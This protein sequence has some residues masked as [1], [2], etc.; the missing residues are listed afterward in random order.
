MQI[1]DNEY[2]KILEMFQKCTFTNYYIAQKTGLSNATLKNYR[3]NKTKPTVANILILKQF[4]ESQ[5]VKIELNS[6][7]NVNADKIHNSIINQINNE[8]NLTD[9]LNE[10]QKLVDFLKE[11]IKTKDETIKILLN[12]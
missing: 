12:K 1:S 11:Q 5:N 4:F 3:E 10:C 6:S 8:K 2:D 7:K 9:Q